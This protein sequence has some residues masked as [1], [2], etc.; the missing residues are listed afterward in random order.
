MDN[1]RDN[2]YGFELTDAVLEHIQEYEED[3]D[4]ESLE[5]LDK[6]LDLCDHT[7]LKMLEDYDSIYDIIDKYINY[8]NDSDLLLEDIVR[9]KVG[10]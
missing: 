2:N 6:I 4:T 10:C 1:L 8:L 5:I 9:N 7:D 3:Q